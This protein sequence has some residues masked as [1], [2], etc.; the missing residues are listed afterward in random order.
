[1]AVGKPPKP[2]GGRMS[3]MPIDPIERIDYCLNVMKA[4]GEIIADALETLRA[5]KDD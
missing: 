2:P 5:V 1:M 3:D 4:H